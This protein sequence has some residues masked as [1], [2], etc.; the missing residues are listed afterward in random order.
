MQSGRPATLFCRVGDKVIHQINGTIS[1]IKKD[2]LSLLLNTDELPDWTEEGKLG[3][4]LLFDTTSYQAMEQA[5]KKVKDASDNRLALLRDIILGSRSA[6][7]MTETTY[8]AL[9]TLNA[10]QN[11]AIKKVNQAKDVA[12][13]HGPPGTGK[14][15]TL[16]EAIIHTL[17][18]EKQ[19]M[20]CSA[21][22]LAVDLLVERLASRQVDV[23]RL[24]NPSRVSEHLLY[25]TLDAQVQTHQDF[26][27]I[28]KLRKSA[29]EHQ[30]MA[31]KYKRR[32]GPEE[33][34][35]RK[36]LYAEARKIS[37]EAISLE[38]FITDQVIEKAQV[39]V[40]TLVGAA[41]ALIDAL[42]YSTVFMDEAAQALEPACWIAV[43]KA[44]RIIMAGDPFQL[45]P[46]V[47]A[48][49]AE[50]QG[51]GKT[52]ME[53][54][55]EEKPETS[56]LLDV[57][58][59]MHE[60]IMGFSNE[61]FYNNQLQA[62]ESVKQATLALAEH[63]LAAPIEFVDTAGC[64]FEEK[65]DPESLSNYN[66]E[67][68]DLLLKHL[69][70]LLPNTEATVGIISPYKAQVNY[71]KE[72]L[73]EAEAR[74]S[75]GTVDG[76]QGQERAIIYIS[77]VRSNAEGQIGFLSDTRRMN[78]ALT[79][80]QKKLVVVGDSATLANHPFYQAFLAYI[81]KIDAYRSAWEWL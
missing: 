81:E 68:A 54:L 7:F 4:D 20:V 13:I 51:L 6:E 66:T 5:L 1:A 49:E 12:L 3:V 19:V 75:V 17:Q 52:L 78:V 34:I 69:R 64:G 29:Q 38:K 40:C 50:N 31:A 63:F 76:F 71:L 72:Q 73:D 60:L 21:S 56:T 62:H 9:P 25:F 35:Q 77:L 22:N 53:K 65:I 70:L 42:T 48:V 30:A 24:G 55:L 46:T 16:V 74:I 41:N 32:F 59:R 18:T 57:Q 10:S 43:S 79:R 58:Y 26:S 36:L 61:Q 27:R 23:V 33:R 28:K 39:I 8:S 47:K 37:K 2:T 15:T 11:E 44:Q 67:E 14:T 45:P 80:A